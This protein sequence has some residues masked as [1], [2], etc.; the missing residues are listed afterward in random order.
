[1][2]VEGW[3][4]GGYIWAER[5]RCCGINGPSLPPDR[6]RL[7]GE[8]AQL[9]WKRS[10]LVIWSAEFTLTCRVGRVDPTAAAAAPTDTT[11]EPGARPRPAIPSLHWQRTFVHPQD[12][13]CYGRDV[14]ISVGANVL[15]CHAEKGAINYSEFCVELHAL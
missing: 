8:S 3:G 14:G 7:R 4:G 2:R 6:S 9:T 5:V 11:T 10:T 13:L 1:M 12:W 15:Q